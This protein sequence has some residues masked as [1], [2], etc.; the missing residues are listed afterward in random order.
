MVCL[1]ASTSFGQQVA[2][3]AGCVEVI[4]VAPCWWV[5]GKTYEVRAIPRRGSPMCACTH[6]TALGRGY[7]AHTQGEHGEVYFDAG[8]SS[9][10]GL[11]LGRILPGAE[12]ADVPRGMDDKACACHPS[13]WYGP[14]LRPYNVSV[15]KP[16][17][18][19]AWA[20]PSSAG[21]CT[22]SLDHTLVHAPKNATVPGS[23]VPRPS[24]SRWFQPR[25][26]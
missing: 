14:P 5:H 15:R 19:P 6:G 16:G 3:P 17:Q 25:W 23:G 11:G 10:D 22:R 13:L 24:H 1:S 20:A 9:Q 7:G 26:D 2:P 18:S 4:L 21:A 12:G 8:S